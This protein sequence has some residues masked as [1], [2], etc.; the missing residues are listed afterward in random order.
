M[1][2]SCK[3]AHR[4][5]PSGRSGSKKKMRVSRLVDEDTR[6]WEAAF[7]EFMDNDDDDIEPFFT[8]LLAHHFAATSQ[9]SRDF[10]CS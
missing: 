7:R 2:E 5:P 8:G 1:A 9:H 4:S 3:Q 10:R 6:D